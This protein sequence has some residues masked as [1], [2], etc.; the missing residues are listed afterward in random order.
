MC[1][2][3]VLRVCCL[4]AERGLQIDSHSFKASLCGWGSGST[5]AGGSWGPP[6]R[7]RSVCWIVLPFSMSSWFGRRAEVFSCECK[8]LLCCGDLCYLFYLLF[9]LTYC[10]LE[11]GFDC[12]RVRGRRRDEDV[13]V[14][15]C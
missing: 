14:V 9:E 8:T 11:I 3:H 4:R 5:V 15:A 2:N 1:F 12:N 10:C 6:P 13:A 7:S